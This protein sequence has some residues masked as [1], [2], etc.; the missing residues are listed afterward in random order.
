MPY[1]LHP[2]ETIYKDPLKILLQYKNIDFTE[3][4]NLVNLLMAGWTFVM[5]IGGLILNTWHNF[6][7]FQNALLAEEWNIFFGYRILSL[8]ASTIAIFILYNLI[9]K[10][11]KIKTLRI[12]FLL[13]IILNPIELVSNNWIK[14]DPFV[15]LSISILLNYSYS[16][17]VL[18]IKRKRKILYILS[19]AAISVRIELVAFFLAIFLQDIYLYYKTLNKDKLINNIKTVLKYILIGIFI[20]CLLTLAPLS[21]VYNHF[22]TSV[23]IIGI[24]KSFHEFIYD[25]LIQNFLNGSL[26]KNVIDNFIFYLSICLF[27]LGPIIFC[28]SLVIFLKAKKTKYLAIFSLLIITVLLLYGNKATHYFLLLSLSFIIT[29]FLYITTIKTYKI[30]LL[31]SW[32]N[33][34]FVSSISA[35]FIFHIYHS[36]DPRIVA[37]YYL[38]AK[39]NPSDLLAIE[40]HSMNGY[41]PPI[42]ECKE[43]LLA[44]SDIIAQIGG[45]TGETYRAKANYASSNCRTILDIFTEDYFGVTPYAKEWINNY[46]LNSFMEKNPKYY[47][48]TRDLYSKEYSQKVLSFYKHILLHYKLEKSFEFYQGD[49]RLQFLLSSEYYFKNVYFYVRLN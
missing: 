32:I 15:Y 5:Y 23:K 9:C 39:T 43:V 24:P 31:F 20:Y 35:L 28:G 25:A 44:K 17:F 29:N 30:Q 40:T 16:Y 13:T 27:G 10:I 41:G 42:D 49:Y 1:C 2:D 47:I 48:T 46:D 14:F 19:V 26:I 45:G 7:E 3:S 6:H 33:F 34:L 4:F 21:Y 38:L 22:F 37:K 11:T 36:E 8:I 12:V 18:G